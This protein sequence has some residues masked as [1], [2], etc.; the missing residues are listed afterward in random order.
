MLLGTG[1]AIRA[2]EMLYH[3]QLFTGLKL[4]EETHMP[5]HMPFW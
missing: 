1:L 2:Y 5:M 4:H 3:I